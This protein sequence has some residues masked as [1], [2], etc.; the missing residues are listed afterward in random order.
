MHRV[1][2]VDD[3]PLNL[4]LLRATLE[5]FGCQVDTVSDPYLALDSA[6]RGRPDLAIV[7]IRMPTMSGIQVMRDLRAD[8]HLQGLRIYA[9]TAAPREDLEE[10]SA[11]M[12]PDGFTGFLRKPGSLASLKDI[13]DAAPAKTAVFASLAMGAP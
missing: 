4:S 1:L 10:I 5:H 3:N 9:F 7:D 12:G 13:L 8:P 6:R 11:L 2:A